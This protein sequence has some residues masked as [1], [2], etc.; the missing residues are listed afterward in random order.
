MIATILRYDRAWVLLLG[1]AV[2]WVPIAW[3]VFN[4]WRA[5]RT[6]DRHPSGR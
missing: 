2:V 1:M 3:S 5:R 4:D 6:R